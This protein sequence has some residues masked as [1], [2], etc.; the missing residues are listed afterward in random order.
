[1][2]W[3]KPALIFLF[4]LKLL[5]RHYGGI[6]FFKLIRQQNKSN[7]YKILIGDLLTH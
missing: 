4:C 5:F 6:I 3:E 2:D 7:I 1:M